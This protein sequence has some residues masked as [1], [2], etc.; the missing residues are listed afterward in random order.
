MKFCVF[1]IWYKLFIYESKGKDLHIRSWV[2]SFGKYKLL[3]FLVIMLY[4]YVFWHWLQIEL[5][6]V[7]TSLVFKIDELKNMFIKSGNIYFCEGKIVMFINLLLKYV[8]N[9]FKYISCKLIL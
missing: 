6:L 8:V 7:Q 9:K 2:Y 4:W 1:F 3:I 5:D